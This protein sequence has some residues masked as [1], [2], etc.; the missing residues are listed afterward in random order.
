MA[1]TISGW[2]GGQDWST[3]SVEMNSGKFLG[4]WNGFEETS[5]GPHGMAVTSNGSQLLAQQSIGSIGLNG[6]KATIDV[7][8]IRIG[9][10]LRFP[11]SNLLGQL[12]F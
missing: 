12:D 2:R 1:S 7:I 11:S 8:G 10:A 3:C 6:W 4:R 9:Y 5:I